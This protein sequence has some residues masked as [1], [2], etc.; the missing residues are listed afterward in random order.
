[1][2]CILLL[3]VAATTEGLAAAFYKFLLIRNADFRNLLWVPDLDQV[4]KNWKDQSSPPDAE[5]GWPTPATATALP[6][7][8]T[9]AKYNP[10]FPVSTRTCISAYGDSFVWGEDVPLADGWIEQLSRTLRCRVANYGVSAYG[11]DQAYIR[12]RDN[13]QD[14]APMVLLGIFSQDIMRTVNQYRAFMGFEP[15]PYWIKGRFVLNGAG[16]LEWI[17]PPRLD[18]ESFVKLH[19]APQLF[20]PSEYLLPDSRDGPVTPSWSYAATLLRVA[21]TPRV[22][23]RLTGSVSTSEFLSPTH[24]SGAFQLTLA[25]VRAFSLEAKRRGQHPLVVMLPG[26]S[27]FREHQSSG[28]YEYDMLV[29]AMAENGIDTFDPAPVLLSRLAGRDY[30]QLY[31]EV[32]ICGRHFGV[33]GSAVLAEVVADELRRRGLT[34]DGDHH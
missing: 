16:A 25:I 31:A 30:C 23:T 29:A 1:M 20:F 26:G 28:H 19:S 10:D 24:P 9:G 27:S 8:S 5:I 14:K 7:D 12:F 6:R 15:Q 18:A 34:G 21:L 13:P 33:S 11:T 3:F 4:R 32:D 22:Q 17:H 2:W